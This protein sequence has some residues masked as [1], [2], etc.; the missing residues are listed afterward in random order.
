MC[1]IPFGTLGDSMPVRKVAPRLLASLPWVVL[2]LAGSF[3]S[4]VL[5]IVQ[6]P[7]PCWLTLLH[8]LLLVLWVAIAVALALGGERQFLASVLL[9]AFLM[10]LAFMAGVLGNFFPFAA[11][12]GDRRLDS[13]GGDFSSWDHWLT[14]ALAFSGMAGALFGALGGFLSWLLRR[15]STV[16]VNGG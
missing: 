5:V 10:S 6:D 4:G 3:V 12:L 8:A 11:G 7:E 15:L 9:G 2:G 13:Y 1:L 14:F 16:H